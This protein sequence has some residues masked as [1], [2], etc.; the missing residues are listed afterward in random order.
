MKINFSRLLKSLYLTVSSGNKISKCFMIA[1]FICASAN[2][3]ALF[4]MSY[5][6]TTRHEM[7]NVG[8]YLKSTDNKPFFNMTSIFAAN[9]NGK[10]E[11]SPYIYLN[12][13]IDK[14]LNNSDT[15][16]ELKAKGIK[17][18]VTLLNNHEMAGWQT[19][20]DPEAAKDFADKIADFL[21]KFD[22]DGVDIDEEYLSPD[23]KTNNYSMIMICKFLKENPKFKGKLLTKALFR[24]SQ[25]FEAV[26][27]KTKL[28][29]LLDYGWYMSYGTDIVSLDYYVQQGMSKEKLAFG[30][31]T[32]NDSA[33]DAGLV[34]QVIADGYG[35]IMVYDIK[36]DSADYLSAIAKAEF[37]GSITVEPKCLR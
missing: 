20:S 13:S 6:E 10:D 7:S 36:N 34:K 16:K 11:N 29:D 3:N 17:V 14:I 18:L 12:D 15:V 23:A 19:M 2:A 30:V 25:Y 8:C 28:V 27:E 1:V 31:S 4:N 24:D 21:I 37:R 33:R 22:L 35:G 9:I 26:Y 5:V 32:N